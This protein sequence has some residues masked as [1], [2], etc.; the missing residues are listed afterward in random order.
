MEIN[1]GLRLIKSGKGED[2]GSFSV[3]MKSGPSNVREGFRKF[4]NEEEGREREK[5]H[6]VRGL[7]TVPLVHLWIE[8][9]AT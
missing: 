6:Q 9:S 1:I 2:D 3:V 4:F 7:S 5:P 8:P